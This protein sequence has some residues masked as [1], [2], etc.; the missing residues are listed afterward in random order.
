M[1]IHPSDFPRLAPELETTIFRIIQEALTNVFR[2]SRASKASVTLEKR[3]GEL[4]ATVRDDGL[5]IPDEIVE[6]RDDSVG[7]GI[8]GMKQRIKELGG[9]LVLK[10]MHPGTLVEAVIPAT[11][12]P[13]IVRVVQTAH[14]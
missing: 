6:F 1:E 12:M 9:E 11:S 8:R 5:G 13:G 2:H 7:V 4:A 10:N 3:E 14:P